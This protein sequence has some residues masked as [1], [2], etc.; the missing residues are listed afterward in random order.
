MRQGSISLCMRKLL[1]FRFLTTDMHSVSIDK[2]VLSF[3]ILKKA[4]RLH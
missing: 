4:E 2:I 1:N 3:D